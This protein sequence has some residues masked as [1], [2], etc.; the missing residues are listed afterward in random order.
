MDWLQ[1]AQGAVEICWEP[2]CRVLAENR[3]GNCECLSNWQLVKIGPVSTAEH[4]RES[5]GTVTG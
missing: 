5:D 2:E 1:L 3:T 4:A